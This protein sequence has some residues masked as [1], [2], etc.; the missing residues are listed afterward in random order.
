MTLTSPGQG[1][2][3]KS[4]HRPW[5]AVSSKSYSGSIRSSYEKAQE[6]VRQSFERSRLE[7]QGERED[8][9]SPLERSISRTMEVSPEVTCY[10]LLVLTISRFESRAK[11]AMKTTAMSFLHIEATPRLRRLHARAA[12]VMSGDAASEQNVLLSRDHCLSTQSKSRMTKQVRRSPPRKQRLSPFSP[13]LNLH[14]LCM[15]N[16][17]DGVHHLSLL[18]TAHLIRRNGDPRKIG[19]SRH[20]KQSL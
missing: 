14:L 15:R 11:N 5:T 20:P 2:D 17:L 6:R 1:S 9:L 8:S 12:K 4:F 19:T 13:R 10:V 18:G 7:D 16:G 3:Q